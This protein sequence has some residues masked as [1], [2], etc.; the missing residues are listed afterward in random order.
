VSSKPASD[1][2]PQES[3]P[4]PP[5]TFSE[6]FEFGK[7]EPELYALWEKGGSFSFDY[8]KPSP[9]L[10]LNEQAFVL[11]M[12]PPNANGE[13]HLGHS[14]GYSIMD[15]LGR[16]YRAQGRR[17][18]LLP[19]KDHAGIQTQVVFENKLR[20][21]GKDLTKMTR[22][23]L[24]DACYAFCMD[25]SNYMRAQEKQLGVSADWKREFFTLD[26]RLTKVIYETF[27]KL[28]NDGLI[29]KGKRIVN[30]SVLSG[31]A[32]SDVEVERKE[33][34]GT[35]TYIR[36]PFVSKPGSPRT[37]PAALSSEAQ[38]HQGPNGVSLVLSSKEYGAGDILTIPAAK[39]GEEDKRLVC[40]EALHVS[41]QTTTLKKLC[42][43]LSVPD[44][45][46]Q[47]KT[48]LDA[49]L[50]AGGGAIS[51]CVSYFEVT[52]DMITATTRPE[53]MLGDTALAVHPKDPRYAHVVGTQVQVPLIG[54]KIPIVADERAEM[55][56]GTGVIKV[57]PAHDFV[58]FDIGATHKL[59]VVQVIGPDGKMTDEAGRFVG[60]EAK[61]CRAQVVADLEAEGRVLRI[62]KIKH[63]VPIAE[64][65]KDIIEPLISEQWFIA[66]DAPGKSLKEKA[67][68][69]VEAGKIQIHPPHFRKEFEHWLKSLRDWNIS[70]QLWWGH[71]LPVWY[72]TGADGK[73]ELFVGSEAPK[74]EGWRQET[75]TFDTWFSSGQW[76]FSTL[77]G[78]G[79]VDLATG[80]SP[81]GAFPS[82]CMQMGRDILFFWACRMLLLTAYRMSEVPWQSIYFT[83]LIRD[84]QGQKMSKS[85]GNGVEPGVMIAK[86][87]ADALRLALLFGTTPGNDVNMGE[88]K[89][90]GYSKFVNKLWNAGKLLEMRVLGGVSGQLPTP[91]KLTSD[92]ARWIVDE[93]NKLRK[94]VRHLMNTYQLGQALTELYSATWDTFCDWYLEIA[95]VLSKDENSPQRGEL[96]WAA[97]YSFGSIVEMLHPFIPYITEE[98]CQKLPGLV[99]GT[100]VCGSEWHAD[101]VF[102]DAKGAAAPGAPIAE[103]VEIVKAIRSS[104]AVLGGL[105][106]G[107]PV[108]LTG[109]SLS[110]EGELL[111]QEL[112]RIRLVKPQE[113][114]AE[115]S[116]KKAFSLGVLTFD[117]PDR[118]GFAQK[119]KK[120]AENLKATIE[121]LESR[122]NSDFAA[123]AR[124]DVVQ[125]ERDKLAT[126]QKT[127]QHLSAELEA[128]GG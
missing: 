3:T 121:R 56:F 47:L 6:H 16:Y 20:A 34:E 77:A 54:R 2:H 91:P 92:A 83:G 41:A 115:R 70:R 123:R 7:R 96:Q 12:P 30:W 74:G 68:A 11:C 98:L 39:E 48:A 110:A 78:C 79:E 31:T 9:K 65:S 76:A 50:A 55:G 22:E 69:L 104:K 80:A 45:L 14:Y 95:K 4:L 118:E 106:S 37:K 73:E 29:Y 111:V 36:Y 84:E 108:A 81:R 53:T 59:P 71:R 66:V 116:V 125:G 86:Y 72:K 62:E 60:L 19:G 122:L 46:G 117:H 87:G 127:L 107:I 128:L 97:Q 64:R 124:P 99:A 58:D 13:L 26:P 27:T 42:E 18:L 51:K 114:P 28:W 85:K 126:A 67:L 93:T 112:G 119:L 89:I 23:E 120:E 35:L 88:G 40:V 1:S 21:E 24:Y 57:T 49:F 75:D 90:G 8:A 63:K 102:S 105:G 44:E 100:T 15:T 32:I 10:P 5:T 113:I 109:G 61:K 25:R 43:E 82:Q 17:V 103:V 38:I 52:E 33:V 94:Q 101:Y